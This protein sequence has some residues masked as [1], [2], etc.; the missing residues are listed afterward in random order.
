MNKI[1]TLIVIAFF[2]ILSINVHAQVKSTK[3]ATKKSTNI[4]QEKP[5]WFADKELTTDR[6]I[7]TNPMEGGQD[8]LTINKNKTGSINRGDI[9]Y[10]LNWEVKGNY[11]YFTSEQLS[12]KLRFQILKNGLIDEYGTKWFD[13]NKKKNEVKQPAK[14]V[15]NSLSLTNNQWIIEQFNTPKIMLKTKS[16]TINIA[17]NQKTFAG[18][19]GCNTINGQVIIEKNKITFSNIISTKMACEFMEQPQNFIKNLNNCNNYKIAG[20]ELFLYKD[21]TL[22]MTLECYK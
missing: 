20:A 15:G 1:I 16:S 5:Y 11:I 22:L 2:T 10:A 7:S 9:V 19:D 14:A 21:E 3:K 4:Q 6:P 13:K 8:A 17:A 12:K 18:S